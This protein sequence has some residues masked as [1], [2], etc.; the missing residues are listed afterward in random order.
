MIKPCFDKV[1][2]EPV[3][4]EEKTASGIYIPDMAASKSQTIQGKILAIGTGRYERGVHIP[5]DF[6]EGEEVLYLRFHSGIKVDVDG[7]ECDLVR[8]ADIIARI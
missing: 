2:I 4:R 5:V 8:E 7:K 3:S 6:K 1:L